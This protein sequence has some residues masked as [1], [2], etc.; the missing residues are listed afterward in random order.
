M[1]HTPGP[2]HVV[3]VPGGNPT[4]KGS[5]GHS[6]ACLGNNRNHGRAVGQCQAHGGGTTIASSA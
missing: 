6:V 3:K 1:K 4:I 5:D 2:W